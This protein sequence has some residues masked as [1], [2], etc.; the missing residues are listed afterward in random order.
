MK[1]PLLQESRK[2]RRRLGWQLPKSF[3]NT[4]PTEDLDAPGKVPSDSRLL[5]T[6]ELSETQSRDI[7]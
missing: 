2:R 3:A 6:P 7:K 5:E 4:A 1:L